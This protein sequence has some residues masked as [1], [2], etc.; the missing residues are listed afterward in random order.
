MG[1]SCYQSVNP[2]PSPYTTTRC[3]ESG[4]RPARVSALAPTADD[5]SHRKMPLPSQLDTL[6]RLDAER[7]SRRCDYPKWMLALILYD[8]VLDDA[9]PRTDQ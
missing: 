7:R 3:R 6:T 1:G 5:A 4:L 2:R 9:K 8:L